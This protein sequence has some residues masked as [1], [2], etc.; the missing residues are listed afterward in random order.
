ML[1]ILINLCIVA[2]AAAACSEKTATACDA[3]A[4]CNWC[5]CAALPSQCWTL[6]DAKKLPAGVY[7]CDK[8]LEEE[9]VVVEKVASHCCDT[10]NKTAGLVKYYSVA[11]DFKDKRQQCGESC[12]DPKDFKTYH[13]FEHNLTLA[14]TNTPCADFGFTDYVETDTHGFGP[15]KATL[16]M[17]KF[18][19]TEV[20][21]TELSVVSKFAT[22]KADFAK[23][24]ATTELEA[25][26]EAAFIANDI[27][28]NEHNAKGLSYWLGHNEFSDMT[29]EE[30][31]SKYVGNA[32]M[33]PTLNRERNFDMSLIN[34]HDCTSLATGPRARRIIYSLPAAAT[35]PPRRRAWRVPHA[36]QM[37]GCPW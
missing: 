4:A 21:L 14:T 12:M 11:E 19:A 15:I 10:C 37:P 6:A 23:T 34:C 32:N 9:E 33:N 22:F 3:D 5:K 26:A 29:W 31:K 20:A 18:P 28:I 30:F 36:H 7:V 27:I 2:S 13:I 24:Y 8:S 1:K 35:A 25:S 16:D 17:Y